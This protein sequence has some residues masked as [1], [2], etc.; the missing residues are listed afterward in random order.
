MNTDKQNDTDNIIELSENL[1]MEENR[2]MFSSLDDAEVVDNGAE[3]SA[4]VESEGDEKAKRPRKISTGKFNVRKLFIF[5]MPLIFL[6]MY[7]AFYVL[8]IPALYGR[9]LSFF[10]WLFANVKHLEKM[11]SDINNILVPAYVIVLLVIL[12]YVLLAAFIASLLIMLKE[13]HNPKI[14]VDESVKYTGKMPQQLLENIAKTLK[15]NS[16][17]CDR[18]TLG[19]LTIVV[20][21]LKYS[22]EF[23]ISNNA[24]ITVLEKEICQLI[25]DLQAKVALGERNGISDCIISVK[26]KNM[27]RD[28]IM[29]K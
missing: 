4:V 19:E 22:K 15:E 2:E 3:T 23:G 12:Q 6:A 27:L 11:L 9:S 29:K 25:D 1:S 24:E 13:L 18:N 28:E 5:G 10:D 14:V 26:Q 21:S 16:S 8:L 20:E 7:I 17:V